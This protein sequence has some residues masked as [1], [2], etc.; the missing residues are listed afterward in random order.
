[1]IQVTFSTS[2]PVHQPRIIEILQQ[3]LQS[4]L[5]TLTLDLTVQ[6]LYVLQLYLVNG[7]FCSGHSWVSC[8]SSFRSSGLSFLSPEQHLSINLLI[9]LIFLDIFNPLISIPFIYKFSRLEK[10]TKNKS[11]RNFLFK[12][13][14]T[15]KKLL[16]VE[17]HENQFYSNKSLILVITEN[18]CFKNLHKKRCPIKIYARSIIFKKWDLESFGLRTQ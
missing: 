4:F 5:V 18:I 2:I 10:Y 8:S 7:I 6:G 11:L 16:K 15:C 14:C 3:I 17:V 1:M 13:D 12:L 9:K